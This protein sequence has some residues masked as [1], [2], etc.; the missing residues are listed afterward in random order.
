MSY[1]QPATPQIIYQIGQPA[2][3]GATLQP[4]EQ[5]IGPL[6]TPVGVQ[7]HSSYPGNDIGT[8]PRALFCHHCSR[9]VTTRV[10]GE[11]FKAVQ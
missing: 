8:E 10:T 2:P 9:Q 11:Y 6:T 1:V 5:S 3:P 7:M 4:T